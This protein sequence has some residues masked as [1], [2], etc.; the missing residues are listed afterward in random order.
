MAAAAGATQDVI[1]QLRARCIELI[2]KALS[3][4]E[5]VDGYENKTD[6]SALIQQLTGIS[7]PTLATT[8]PSHWLW[9]YW[10]HQYHTSNYR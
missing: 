5:K 2:Q 6:M 8:P 4:C 3:E 9:R 7:S 1:E 10:K